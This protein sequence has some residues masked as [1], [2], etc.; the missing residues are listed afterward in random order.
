MKN[1]FH[2]LVGIAI[3][4]AA[5][6]PLALAASTGSNQAMAS[7]GNEHRGP[8]VTNAP[9]YRVE[10]NLVPVGGNGSSFRGASGVTD[11]PAWLPTRIVNIGNRST[12]LKGVT[13]TY[14]P[15]MF[16]PMGLI[17]LALGERAPSK[18]IT[19]GTIDTGIL[20]SLMIRPGDRGKLSV[21]VDS[22]HSELLGRDNGFDDYTSPS[23]DTIQ[24]V[25]Y[26]ETRD[27]GKMDVAPGTWRYFV[28]E[29][30]PYSVTFTVKQVMGN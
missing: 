22:I 19:P 27:I 17:T 8:T 16:D 25:K 28:R 13:T 11:I 3:V 18:E 24:L 26:H 10:W 12:Y 1:V 6:S 23:G 4:S 2:A 7:V 29:G 21:G 20:V 15:R 30:M 14:R 9:V 5:S